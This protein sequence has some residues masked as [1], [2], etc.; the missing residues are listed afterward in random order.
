MEYIFPSHP[1]C[2]Q[3]FWSNATTIEKH[4]LTRINKFEQQAQPVVE[5]VLY[6]MFHFWWKFYSIIYFSYHFK[7]SFIIVYQVRYISNIV[8]TVLCIVPLHRK[9]RSWFW[10]PVSVYINGKPSFNVFCAS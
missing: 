2:Q 1:S 7:P 4:A 5:H 9:K 8:L 6:H 10:H 3:V